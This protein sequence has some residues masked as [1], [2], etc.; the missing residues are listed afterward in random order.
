MLIF[1]PTLKNLI[2]MGGII[3]VGFSVCKGGKIGL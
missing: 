1:S 3:A 2:M